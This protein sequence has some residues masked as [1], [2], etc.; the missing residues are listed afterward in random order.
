MKIAY[1]LNEFPVLYNT[2]NM[3]QI[4]Q[5]VDKGIEV[6]IVALNRVDSQVAHADTSRFQGQTIYFRQFLLKRSPVLGRLA[7]KYL[8]PKKGAGRRL[9][10]VIGRLLFVRPRDGFA[11]E[12]YVDKF[13][14]N[15]FAFG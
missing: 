1:V 5:L 14:W 7:V 9:D 8:R 4:S 11:P 6:V 2:Y 15:A 13:G 3:Y 10:I 12:H